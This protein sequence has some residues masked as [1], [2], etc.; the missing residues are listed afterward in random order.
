MNY[1]FGGGNKKVISGFENVEKT[2]WNDIKER[3][4]L[5]CEKKFISTHKA[6]RRCG[7]CDYLLIDNC[8]DK[9]LTEQKVRLSA[10]RRWGRVSD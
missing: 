8:K 10:S 7:R 2:A 1:T 4:C 3:K 5:M 9:G 6:H